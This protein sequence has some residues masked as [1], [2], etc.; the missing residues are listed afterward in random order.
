MLLRQNRQMWLLMSFR[1][2]TGSPRDLLHQPLLARIAAI[3]GCDQTNL[4][5][6]QESFSRLRI[7]I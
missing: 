3:P 5:T 7:P 4:E 1:I 6:T 2:C